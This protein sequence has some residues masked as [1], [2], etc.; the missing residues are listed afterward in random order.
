MRI[1]IVI[2]PELPWTEQADLWRRAERYGFDHAWTYDHLSWYGLADSPW[3]ATIP[4]LTAAATVTSTIRLGTFVASPN[5]RH[6]VP[7]AKEVATVDEISGGR[8]ILGVGAG[9]GGSGLDA[10][11]LGTPVL[12]PRER[13]ERFVEFTRDLDRLLRFEEP[14]SDGI[15]FT[16][17][18]FTG[19]RA[20]MV[21][22]PAQRPRVPLAVAADGP[23][24][25]RF[26]AEIADAW[27]TLGHH[28]DSESEWWDGVSQL[29]ARSQDAEAA[30]GRERPLDR[31]L[32]LDAGPGYSLASAA[33]FEDCVGRAAELGFTDVVT[34]WPRPDGVYAGD[35]RVLDEIAPAAH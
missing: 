7:F 8:L 6:P 13:H 22:E 4:T 31:I 5:Y 21:G 12:T 30:V 27:I 23:R 25:I 3:G 1:G 11:V 9:A 24:G 35:E 34:H 26:A 33:K 19:D 16:G 14:G 20:R 29:I 32:S 15:S 10:T 18:W 2:L 28:A 17:D